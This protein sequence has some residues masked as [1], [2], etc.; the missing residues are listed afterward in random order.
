M[1]ISSEAQATLSDYLISDLAPEG[2]LDYLACHGFLTA[3]AVREDNFDCQAILPI[4]IDAQPQFLTSKQQSEIESALTDLF[5]SISRMLYL[6]DEVELPM[7]L[8][9][10][11][12]SHSNDLT[13]WCFGFMEAIAVFEDDWF[14]VQTDIEPI[15]DLILPITVFSEPHVDPELAHLV[16]TDQARQ[17]LVSAIPEN[18]QQLYLL[19]RD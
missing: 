16:K 19:F 2:C 3:L 18:I 4:I 13:D 8:K 11:K 10:A 6:G 14:T 15:A 5:N 1:Q 7:S 12:N 17:S 9:P